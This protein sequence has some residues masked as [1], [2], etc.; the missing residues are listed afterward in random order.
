MA[1]IPL[2]QLPKKPT[3]GYT[4]LSYPGDLIADGRWLFEV[5]LQLHALRSKVEALP[6]VVY[7]FLFVFWDHMNPEYWALNSFDDQSAIRNVCCVYSSQ[8]FGKLYGNF[9][10]PANLGDEGYRRILR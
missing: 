3:A 8:R 5:E 6:S 4:M 9:T 7:L 10:Y 1:T 2:P